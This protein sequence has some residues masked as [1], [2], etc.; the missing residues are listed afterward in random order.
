MTDVDADGGGSVKG[1]WAWVRVFYKRKS[2][3]MRWLPRELWFTSDVRASVRL[4]LKVK[5]VSLLTSMW[6]FNEMVQG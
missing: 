1:A 2:M 4:R 5:I 3:Q 6:K